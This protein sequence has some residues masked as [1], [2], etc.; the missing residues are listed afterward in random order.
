MT[1]MDKT[2]ELIDLLHFA[3]MTLDGLGKEKRGQH[4]LERLEALATALEESGDADG[5][6][7]RLATIEMRIHRCMMHDEDEALVDLYRRGRDLATPGTTKH[8]ELAS[9]L[10]VLLWREGRREEAREAAVAAIES[11]LGANTGI[12]DLT[13]VMTNMKELVGPCAVDDE[14]LMNALRTLARRRGD[15]AVAEFEREFSENA[16]QAVVRLAKALRREAGYNGRGV[17]G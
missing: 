2:D 6:A 10:A 3:M 15:E 17:G 11:A 13:A 5:P 7:W 9:W 1:A 4:I 8:C 14:R 12:L 16:E